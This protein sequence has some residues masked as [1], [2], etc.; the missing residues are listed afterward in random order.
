MSELVVRTCVPCHGGAPQATPEEVARYRSQVPDWEVVE[1][2]GVAKLRRAFDFPDFASALAFTDAVGAEAEAQG[3]HP[4]LVTTWGKVTVSWWTHA[5]G[6]LHE[7]DFI[8][9][10]RTDALF[11]ER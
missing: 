1:E 9:A 8:M 6:G 5:I 3:H 2:D 7:N 10:A 11:D 4:V